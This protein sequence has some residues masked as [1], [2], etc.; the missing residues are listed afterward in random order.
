MNQ[1]II[2]IIPARGGSKRIPRK[3]IK[4]FLGKPVISFSIS[5]ALESNLFQEVMVSTDDEE[6]ANIAMKYGAKVPFLRSPETSND[7][8]ETAA[9]LKEVLTNYEKQGQFFDMVCCIYPVAP[10]ISVSKIKEAFSLIN[11]KKLDCCFPVC[12]Y[13]SPIWR[14]I[15]MDKENKVKMIWPE[16]ENKRTQDLP[17][18]FFEAGQF[19]WFN[20]QN[21]LKTGEFMTDATGAI[22]L[23][24]L[25]VQD[26]DTMTDWKLA[27]LKFKLIN[28]LI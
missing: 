28:N 13:S 18:S 3:N 2:A 27:E 12:L 16:N 25:H 14:A 22:V 17:S 11:E 1:R 26:I 21:F 10:L 15:E 20:T 23:D 9:V 5:A 4:D 7:F 8:A 24:D 19:F 6:I